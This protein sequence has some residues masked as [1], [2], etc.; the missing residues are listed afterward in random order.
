M[1][2]HTPNASNNIDIHL[3][4]GEQGVRIYFNLDRPPDN[5]VLGDIYTPRII[6]PHEDG[7]DRNR[8]SCHEGIGEG[9]QAAEKLYA[10]DHFAE[11]EGTNKYHFEFHRGNWD[12]PQYL[13]LKAGHDDDTDNHTLTVTFEA[14]HPYTIIGSNQK[15]VT[16]SNG[17]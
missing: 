5:G 7:G 13:Y 9:S 17:I 6:F 2:P 15:T 11:C 1:A 16:L 8:I 12:T 3:T 10:N 14:N 4:E